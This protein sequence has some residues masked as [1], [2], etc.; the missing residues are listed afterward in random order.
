MSQMFSKS[1]DD[2][3]YL[4]F[5]KKNAYAEVLEIS[6]PKKRLIEDVK[7]EGNYL[8]IKFDD[9][10]SSIIKKILETYWILDTP[11]DDIRPSFNDHTGYFNIS[12]YYDS[13]LY[14]DDESMK[15]DFELLKSEL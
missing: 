13:G 2:L 7:I 3:V 6:F 8:E 4:R 10:M 5:E 15:K 12:Y 11:T 14:L 1:T 9:S